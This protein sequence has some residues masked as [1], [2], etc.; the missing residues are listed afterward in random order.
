MEM[1]IVK[2]VKKSGTNVSTHYGQAAIKTTAPI[3]QRML[4]SDKTCPCENNCPRC[5]STP[6]LTIQLKAS[7][8]QSLATS[9]RQPFESKL[10]AVFSGG[11][12]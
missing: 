10:G 9:V 2:R 1:K 12:K 4:H 5:V 8:G 11:E 3:I 6:S 7:Q